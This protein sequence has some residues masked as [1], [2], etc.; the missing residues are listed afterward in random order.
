MI[1]LFPLLFVCTLLFTGCS[2]K[3]TTNIN[4]QLNK[5]IVENSSFEEGIVMPTGWASHNQYLDTSEAWPNQEAHTGKSSLMIDNIGATNAY[6]QGKDLKFPKG[7]NSFD[8][9]LWTKTKSISKSADLFIRL[10][11]TVKTPNSSSSSTKVIT[12]P[13]KQLEKWTKT[14]KTAL[15]DKEIV[16]VVPYFYLSNRRGTTYFDDF[17]IMPKKINL[18]SGKV[19]FDSNRPDTQFTN[20]IKL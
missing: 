11:V 19:L 14:K 10:V 13:L 16:K 3:A 5:N 12:I 18:I 7:Y 2:N 1:K 4:N 17:S 9:M 15:Y 8:I 6:W 20:A